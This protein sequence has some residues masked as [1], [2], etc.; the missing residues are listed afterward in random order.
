MKK[1]LLELCG[2]VDP[3]SATSL[4]NGT[5]TN[6]SSSSSSSGSHSGSHTS[7]S[8][9]G[10]GSGTGSHTTPPTPPIT[11]DFNLISYLATTPMILTGVRPLKLAVTGTIMG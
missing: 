9:S 8:G 3:E 4:G 10:S 7:G 6:S 1:R 2:I 11:I 5:I